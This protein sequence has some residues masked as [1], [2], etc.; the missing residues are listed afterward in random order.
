MADLKA[1]LVHG[2]ECAC[3]HEAEGHQVSV[4][5][6]DAPKIRQLSQ[7]PVIGKLGRFL[8]W[9]LVFFGIYASS[10]VCPFCGTPG[11]PVGAGAAGLVGGAFAVFWTYGK[12]LIDEIKKF[13]R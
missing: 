12:N 9:W 5:G 6:Q 8:S 13:F 7:L 11:C 10:S 4:E 1:M 2:S 3:P